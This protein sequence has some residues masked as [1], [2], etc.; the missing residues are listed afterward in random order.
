MPLSP[1]L[2]DALAAASVQVAPDE[3]LAKKTWWRVGGAADGYAE[4][5]SLLQL[6]AV[7]RLCAEASCPVFPLGNASNLLIS[8]L[9]I[10]GLVIR[11]T[12]EL[13][14]ADRHPDGPLELG[15]GLKLVSFLRKASQ[16]G[17]TGLEMVAG[18]PGTIGGAVRMNAGTR[19]GEISDRILSAGLVL[20]DGTIES[21]SAEEL[22]LSYRTSLLPDGAVVAW[23]RFTLTDSDPEQ[24]KALVAEHLDYRARTQPTDVPT[25]GSTFRNPQGDH[26]GRLIE[27]TGLK[28]LTIGAAQVSDKHANFIVNTGG[29]TAADLRALIEEVQRRVL[30]AHGVQLQREVHYAGEW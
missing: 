17:W 20:A 10:R 29:A 22:G 11:L 18:V 8:D 24:S 1:D 14:R 30:E 12:G 7:Q 26:A 28:G 6:S 5:E 13:A 27:A 16:E 3:P 25:C 15:G 21:R 9:G 23:A 2:V 4:V 19:L